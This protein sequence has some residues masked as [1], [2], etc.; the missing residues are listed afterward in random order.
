M[1]PK[2]KN[3]LESVTLLKR[4]SLTYQMDWE[5]NK[6]VSTCDDLTAMRQAVY[7]ILNTQRYGCPIYSWNYGIEL[8][9]LI[10]MPVNYCMSEI[11]RRITEALLQDDRIQRVYDFTFEL[12]KKNLVYAEF[13][14]ETAKGILTARKE[15][16]I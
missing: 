8:Q 4:P 6:I 3:V 16:M 10:G 5:N 7:K 11:E 1:I 12:A 15:V 9:D 14:V 13:C 2:Q